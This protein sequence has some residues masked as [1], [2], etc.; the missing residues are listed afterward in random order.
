MDI[1]SQDACFLHCIIGSIPFKYMG[2]HV[3][4]N[5]QSVGTWDPLVNL[6]ARR[7]GSWRSRFGSHNGMVVL[8]NYVLNSIPIF[9]L[10]FI[11]ILVKAWKKSVHL[12]RYS[13]GLDGAMCVDLNQKAG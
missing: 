8:I 6:I 10:S 11:K 3:G 7:L 1:S 9:Y 2:F 4:V 5:P 13:F 12:N